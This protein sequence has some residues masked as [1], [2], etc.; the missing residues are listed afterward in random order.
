MSAKP[1]ATIN[2]SDYHKN[3]KIKNMKFESGNLITKNNLNF[4]FFF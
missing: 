2:Y 3:E 1:E 4:L